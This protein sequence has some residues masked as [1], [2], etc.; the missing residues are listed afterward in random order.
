MSNQPNPLK[1]TLAIAV[2]N[3]FLAAPG[4]SQTPTGRQGFCVH[5][6]GVNLPI[7]KFLLIRKGNQVGALRLTRITRD[8]T[9]KPRAGEWLG[10]V[11]Y[12]SYFAEGSRPLND[13]SA[14]KTSEK[15]KFGRI[16]GFGFH[17]SFQSG[18]MTARVG[19]WK[20]LFFDEDGM[21]MTA[22]DRWN[23]IDH[24]SG[25]EFAPTGSTDLASANP[26]DPRLH[27]YRQDPNTDIP[28]PVPVP[29]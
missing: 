27:W 16:K 22:Y 21:F 1:L 26:Q 13:S 28:C 2:C 18:N 9:T 3:L 20:F 11:A 7:G 17:Y 25:L 24:D 6:S 10:T 15:L 12:E 29:N 5:G 14:T 23:G 4:C 19:P 8:T